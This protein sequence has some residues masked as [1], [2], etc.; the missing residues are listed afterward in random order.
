MQRQLLDQRLA[1][2]VVVVHDQNLA[3]GSHQLG[4]SRRLGKV[5][6]GLPK[7]CSETAV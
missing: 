7:K 5:N 3:G 1:Q 4:S 2:I 6:T